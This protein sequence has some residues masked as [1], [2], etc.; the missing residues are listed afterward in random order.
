LEKINTLAP[1]RKWIAIVH[2]HAAPDLTNKL[3][4]LFIPIENRHPAAPEEDNNHQGY[5]CVYSKMLFRHTTMATF[6]QFPV[7]SPHNCHVYRANF[8]F[9]D[10][11]HTKHLPR[12]LYRQSQPLPSLYG[13]EACFTEEKSQNIL[14]QLQH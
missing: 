8:Y 5:V 2:G 11:E 3:I 13:S 10:H 7:P 6:L 9:T 1:I 12:Y 4:A 14:M